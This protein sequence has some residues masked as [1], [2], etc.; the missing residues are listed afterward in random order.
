M[1]VPASLHHIGKLFGFGKYNQLIVDNHD[2][3][4]EGSYNGRLPCRFVSFVNVKLPNGLG[5]LHLGFLAF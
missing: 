4:L 1:K 3:G 2:S 5:D